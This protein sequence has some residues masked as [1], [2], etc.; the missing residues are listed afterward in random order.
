[1]LTIIG[2]VIALGLLITVHEMGHFLAARKLGVIVEKFS[3]GFGPK[4]ISFHRWNVDFRISLIPLGGYVKMKGENPGEETDDIGSY[5][6]KKWWERAIIAF[7]GPFANLIFAIL[8]FILSFLIGRSYE[9]F[10]PVIGKLDE[11]EYSTLQLKDEILELNGNEIS[12]WTQLTK[13]TNSDDENELLLQRNGELV[14]INLPALEPQIWLNEVLPEAPAVIGDVSPGYP[15][16]KAGL[17]KLDEILKVNGTEVDSWYEMR[18]LITSSPGENVEL[19]IRRGDQIFNKTM[20]LEDNIL[21][22]N[23]IIGIIQY[24][25]LEFRE[26]YSLIESIE[27]G[28]LSTVSFIVLNYVTLYKLISKPSAIKQ[29]LGGPVMILSMTKQSADKGLD[30]ALAFMAAISL[31]LMIMN[32]LPIPI[33][34]GGHIF[35]CFIEGIFRK[36]LS[37]RVQTVLQNIGLFFLMSLMIFAFFNDFSKIFTRNDSINQQNSSIQN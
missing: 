35:F 24:M 7:A 28:T 8:I 37:L 5:K 22:E 4:L 27:Y 1:M 34:D 25:P 13:H 20:K 32:L 33:L 6:T 9:D 10:K 31:I 19:E 36:P 29:N 2:A 16:Y 11:T 3:L 15:A 23:R 14:T 12:T 18:E 17:M 26:T 21:D 30:T